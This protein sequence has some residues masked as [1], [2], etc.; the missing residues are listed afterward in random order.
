M[1]PSVKLDLP[2]IRSQLAKLEE[3]ILSQRKQMVEV[4]S[5]LSYADPALKKEKAEEKVRQIIPKSD[6]T[7]HVEP[8]EM[9][10]T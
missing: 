3:S 2:E 7:I 10:G 6:V 5:K 4:A 1:A 9:K 8:L